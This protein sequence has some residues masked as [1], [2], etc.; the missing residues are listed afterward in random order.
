M[1]DEEWMSLKY[2]RCV[3]VKYHVPCS[4]PSSYCPDFDQWYQ[5][6]VIN[7]MKVGV[8]NFITE[9]DGY[10]VVCGWHSSINAAP[11]QHATCKNVCHVY[12]LSYWCSKWDSLSHLYRDEINYLIPVWL[13]MPKIGRTQLLHRITWGWLLSYGW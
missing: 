10:S 13:I 9:K 3:Y 8:K 5:R 4:L 1:L 11:M 12:F 6:N 2:K 7:E